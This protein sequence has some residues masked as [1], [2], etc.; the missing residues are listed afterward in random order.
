MKKPTMKLSVMLVSALLLSAC[1]GGGGSSNGSNEPATLTGQFKDRNVAGLDY[2]SASFTGKTDATGSFK[3]KE[4]E[5][6]T[7]SVGGI[8]LGKSNGK[9]V[10]TAIDL[11]DNGAFDTPKVVNINQLLQTLDSDGDPDNEITISSDVSE[12]AKDWKDKVDLDAKD[13]SLEAVREAAQLADASHTYKIPDKAEVKA[14]FEKTLRCAYAGAYRGSYSGDASGIFG[15]LVWPDTSMKLKI[16]NEAEDVLR[17]EYIYPIPASELKDSIAVKSG[18]DKTSVQS[19][20]MV[21]KGND[22]SITS[23]LSFEGVLTP[24][25]ISGSWKENN[26]AGVFSGKKIE[27]LATPDYRYVGGYYGDDEGLITFDVDTNDQDPL[28]SVKGEVVSLLTGE[29]LTG[30]GTL[31]M[32]TGKLDVTLS[33]GAKVVGRKDSYSNSIEMLD[34]EWGNHSDP[35]NPSQG[36]MFVKGCRLN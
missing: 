32:V 21:S 1:G 24:Q 31:N 3:Y 20:S 2:K 9:S 12:A 10:V 34:G 27:S 17:G 26:D 36:T 29:R 11:V 13:M 18:A 23:S 22:Y 19:L 6:V 14:H 15:M 16:Y 5:E 35:S 30:N 4:G 33:N 8:E 7:F 25:A 28:S